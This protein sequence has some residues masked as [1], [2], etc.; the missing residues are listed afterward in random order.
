M[1]RLII[2]ISALVLTAKGMICAQDPCIYTPEARIEKL[3]AQSRDS[4]KYEPDER[5][6]FLEKSVE[7]APDCLPCLL[8][9][10]ELQF[11]RA[12]RSGAPFSPAIATLEKITVA[13]EWYHSDVYYML[14]SMCYA[15][16][17]YEKA[18]GY[19]GKFLRF[20][21]DDPARL[22][23]KYPEQYE[24]VK[25]ALASV[26]EYVEIYKNQ[27]EFKPRK[28]AG[29]SSDSDDYL[30]LIS[31]DG[32]IMF[33][34][35]QSY[36]KALGD[37]EPR[38]QEL[39]TW[40]RRPDINQSFDP[41]EALPP[42]FNRGD[43]YGGATVSVDNKELIIARKNPQPKNPQNID[44]FST[45]YTRTTDAS[46]KTVYLWEELKQLGPDIN[47]PDGWEG[48]P[49]LSGDGQLLFFA[50]VRPTCLKD[51]NGN[52]TH[53]IFVSRRQTD[54]SWGPANPV[55][56]SINTRMHEKAPFMHSDSR[57]LYFSSNGHTGVGGM[58]LFYCTMN[59]D[60]T[61][62][63]PKNMGFPINDEKDQLGIVVS[64]DGEIAY[65]GANKLNGEKGWDVYEFRLPERARP[66][67]VAIIKGEVRNEEGTAAQ[68]AEVEIKYVQSGAADKVRVN[69]D[70]GTYAAVVRMDKKED[71][72]L[73]VKGEDIAFNSRVI[74]RKE[75]ELPPV[76]MKL[77][78]ETQ[79]L[80]EDKPFVIN[81]I[82]YATGRAELDPSSML[83][84]DLFAEYL[85][86]HPAME[87]EIQ[88]HTDNVG[89]EKANL[90]LSKERAFEVLSYLASRGVEGSRLSYQGYGP[91]RPVADNA[92]EEGRARNR[93]TEFVVRKK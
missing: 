85:T 56:G 15:D 14:G 25:V 8:R 12:K 9:M 63:K 34:T 69:G 66:E 48:Q 44:L 62:S 3:L 71:V 84:L 4:K 81:D 40:S 19:L 11:L 92:T 83:I 10:G 87:I 27:P 21:D 6:G 2:L 72:V 61:F 23:K 41:G 38:L 89:S 77:S 88:G 54:G 68:N 60:G 22:D 91:L 64:S 47:T 52:F 49:S 26:E 43:N 24:E 5:M 39:F 32:E 42:P 57:T 29:V 59:E 67:R 65:F 7:E 58:D 13:C 55:G 28:V 1:N 36:T 16:K 78:M 76:V 37:F 70:D 86:E 80:A 53:D 20:P 82:Y 46:G 50:T 33:Y 35:R 90:A 45:R 17:E 74:A 93:R 73:Q 18:A 75:D 30:P 31:P 79:A 51:V